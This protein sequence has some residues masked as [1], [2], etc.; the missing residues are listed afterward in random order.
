MTSPPAGLTCYRDEPLIICAFILVNPGVS[1]VDALLFVEKRVRL[2]WVVTVL[3][4]SIIAYLSF[5]NDTPWFMDPVEVIGKSL[6]MGKPSLV[7][8][9]STSALISLAV[10][11]I[12]IPTHLPPHTLGV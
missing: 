12:V 3:L 10:F 1:L 11:I 6:A 9:L 2:G 4:V 7:R 5:R 8:I